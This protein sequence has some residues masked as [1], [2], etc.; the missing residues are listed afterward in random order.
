MPIRLGVGTSAANFFTLSATDE[1]AFDV[2]L[3]DRRPVRIALDAVPQLLVLEHVEAFVGHAEVVEDLHDLGRE[4]AHREL[5]ITLHEQ[6]DV[7]AL[8]FIVDE[9]VDGHG[10]FLSRARIRA[11]VLT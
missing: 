5:R 10:L 1:L 11:V 8:H 3:G 2:E 6:H 7:V 4:S 9:L